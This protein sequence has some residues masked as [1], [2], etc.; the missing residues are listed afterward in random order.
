MDSFCSLLRF[1]VSVFAAARPSDLLAV[2]G[3]SGLRMGQWYWYSQG[4][5]LAANTELVA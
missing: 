3:F 4:K 1:S 5:Q 2:S